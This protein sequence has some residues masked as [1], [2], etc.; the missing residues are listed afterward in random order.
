ML[1]EQIAQKLATEPQ[2]LE[3]ESLKLYV[4]KKL[5]IIESEL[6]RLAHRYGV[7]N[8]TE[9]DEMIKQGKYHEDEAFEDYFEFDNLESE[10]DT[11]VSVLESL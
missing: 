11:L 6:L 10:R 7:Q 1:F 2:T 8:V 5:R 3:R 4:E 9:L